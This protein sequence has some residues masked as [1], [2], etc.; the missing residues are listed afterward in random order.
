MHCGTVHAGGFYTGRFSVYGH[1]F[2]KA[3]PRIWRDSTCGTL[4]VKYQSDIM[5]SDSVSKTGSQNISGNL[6]FEFGGGTTN[7]TIVAN[8]NPIDIKLTGD[9]MKPNVKVDLEKVK[10]RF[11]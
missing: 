5:T 11:N 10:R 7:I 9:I 4:T 1:T 8:K 6:T 3:V 2:Q